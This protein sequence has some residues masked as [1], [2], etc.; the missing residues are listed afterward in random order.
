VKLKTIQ[1]GLGQATTSDPVGG[2]VG[3]MVRRVLSV[4]LR[5]IKY[6]ENRYNCTTSSTDH[7]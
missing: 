1:R 7:L 6:S 5:T 4:L 3:G 2:D